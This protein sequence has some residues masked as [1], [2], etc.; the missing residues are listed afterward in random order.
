MSLKDKGHDLLKVESFRH[1]LGALPLLIATLLHSY[2]TRCQQVF[3]QV[4]TIAKEYYT[5]I[6]GIEVTEGIKL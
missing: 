1:L 5:Q 2:L 4:S 3:S 6:K